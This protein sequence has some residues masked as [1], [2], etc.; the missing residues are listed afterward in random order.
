MSASLVPNSVLSSE[1][2][3]RRICSSD[4]GASSSGT[5]AAAM[6]D[7]G[8]DAANP[9]CPATFPAGACPEVGMVRDRFASI[10][11]VGCFVSGSERDSDFILPE[12]R[13]VVV[14]E[15]EM[16]VGAVFVLR[17]AMRTYGK[18]IIVMPTVRANCN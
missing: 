5:S 6:D 13:A 15:W 4:V 14:L 9:D 17:P 10:E 8:I 7:F 2:L 12:R 11:P 16:K 18:I 3:K 1:V